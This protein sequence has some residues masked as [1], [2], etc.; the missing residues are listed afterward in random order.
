MI[1]PLSCLEVRLLSRGRVAPLEGSPD[2]EAHWQ[3]IGSIPQGGQRM[4]FVR[5]ELAGASWTALVQTEA[6]EQEGLNLRVTLAQQS[7]EHV[8]PWGWHHYW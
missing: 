5:A 4:C 3:V 6:L 8:P 2:P 7:G 1:S